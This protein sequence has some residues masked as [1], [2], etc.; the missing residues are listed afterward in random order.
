MP[1]IEQDSMPNNSQSDTLLLIWEIIL[2]DFWGA[3]LRP[4]VMPYR[5]VLVQILLSVCFVG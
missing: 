1:N 4:L 5:R 2:R 3:I